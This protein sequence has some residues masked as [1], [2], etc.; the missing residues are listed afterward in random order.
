MKTIP[1]LWPYCY[2]Y[3]DCFFVTLFVSIFTKGIPG[4]FQYYVTLEVVIDQEKI[5][6]AGDLSVQSLYDGD[7]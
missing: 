1:Y 5:D 7:A 6:P 2:R 3:C 4:F